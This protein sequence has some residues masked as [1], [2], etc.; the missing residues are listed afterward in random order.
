MRTARKGLESRREKLEN[1]ERTDRR[2]VADLRQGGE[3]L[4]RDWKTDRKELE[5][6]RKGSEPL[7]SGENLRGGTNP[8]KRTKGFQ[9][10]RRTARKEL[11]SRFVR[12]QKI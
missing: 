3:P 6:L 9:K 5:N 12:G 8:S 7:E 2:G 4:E 1:E 10:E 11:E